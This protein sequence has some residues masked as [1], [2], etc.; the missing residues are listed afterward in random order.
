MHY[1][2][3]FLATAIL[4]L[5][6][7]L[8]YSET[9]T[10]PTTTPTPPTAAKTFS[11]ADRAAIEDIIQDYL[12]NKH[13][14]IIIQ[15]AQEAQ[16]RDQVSAESKSKEA[17]K[18]AQDKIFNDPSSPVGGNPKGDIT[19]VEF[20][21]YQCGYCKMSEEH[22]EKLLTEDK[23]VKFVYK[24]FP[25]LGP[26]STE[27]AKAALA[28]VKQNKYIKFHDAL[29]TK[30]DHLNDDLIYQLAKESGID[31]EKLKKDMAAPEIAKTIQD[32]L[33]LGSKIG[34]RGT[35]MFIIGDQVYPGA[36]QQY[37][38]MKQAVADARAAAKKQ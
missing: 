19:V 7:A 29:M 13:P 35:P 1:A 27:A 36:I 12:T 16:K 20:F 21:D 15:A 2:P 25:I 6:P 31:V 3:L 14:E 30:R 9:T 5:A 22:V 28:S 18:T 24:D 34:V 32:N 38:Q 23:G 37:S 17:V 26:M 4:S 33:E 10:A 11:D 8:S